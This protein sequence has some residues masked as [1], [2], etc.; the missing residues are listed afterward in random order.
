MEYVILG[1]AVVTIGALPPL[2]RAFSNRPRIHPHALPDVTPGDVERVVRR[3]FRSEQFENVMIILKE[4]G[5]GPRVR[6]AALKL[7]NGDANKL[8]DWIDAAK[9]DYRD[10]LVAAEYPEHFK[11]RGARR[12]LPAKEEQRLVDADWRQYETWL[13]R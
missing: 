12:Q 11:I 13:R 4:Y 3:D 9:R 2:K 1:L 6:L 5:E 8:Q 7:A 10:L